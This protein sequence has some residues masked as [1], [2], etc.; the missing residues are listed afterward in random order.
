MW[1]LHM[2]PS[3]TFTQIAIRSFESRD[4]T[5]MKQVKSFPMWYRHQAPLNVFECIDLTKFE[6][7]EVHI[8][9]K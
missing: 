1:L 7:F 4:W 8:L 5:Q 3:K 9:L 6:I 2:I